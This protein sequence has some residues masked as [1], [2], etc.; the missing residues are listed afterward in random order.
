M[1]NYFRLI[2]CLLL[3][4]GTQAANEAPA[5]NVRVEVQMVSVP[6]AKALELLPNLRDAGS[7]DG[8][9]SQIQK[10][11]VQGEA[12]LIA[13]PEVTTKRGQRAVTEDIVEVRYPTGLDPAN[14]PA[15]EAPQSSEPQNGK[16]VDQGLTAPSAFET[17]NLGATLEVEPVL[18]PDA[19][20]IDVNLVPQHVG[21]L[22][23]RNPF[24]G[25]DAHGN[26]PGSA[27][28]Q[29]YTAKTTTNLTVQ[30][31]QRVLLASFRLREP[32]DH[33]LFFILKAESLAVGNT[34][35]KKP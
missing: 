1:N 14:K 24:G 32:A 34:K 8:A 31:G 17:R 11:I 20:S 27:Q 10:M 21:L 25:K 16:P 7:I 22:G 35:A 13:W 12:S 2:A 19:Q 28:P 18:S 23:F 26:D 15:P 3:S 29:F 9:F 30:N 5:M 6:L 33:L 4:A